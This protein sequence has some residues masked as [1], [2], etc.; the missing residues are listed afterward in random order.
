MR[1]VVLMALAATALFFN[2]NAQDSTPATT[3]EDKGK[4]TFSG[5][6]D[7]YYL[8]NFNKPLS[9]LNT[10]ASGLDEGGVT[11]IGGNA[12]AFDAV[13][14]QF[15]LG[16]VQT[17][18]VYS[19]KKSEAVIDLTFGPNADLGNYGNYVGPLGGGST[20]LAIKQAYFTYKATD[21]L[22]FTAGQFGTHIGYEVIDAPI[23]YNYSLS[24]LFNNGPF[25]HIGL[26]GTYA[27]S[28]KVALMAGIVNN[29]DNL[30]DNNRAK[31]IISQLYVQPV[32]GWN[33]YLN[34]IGSN[35]APSQTT[36]D[37]AYYSLFD[38][39]TSYQVTEKFF[40][41]L[42]AAMGS[43]KAGSGQDANT[44][45]GVALYSNVAISDVFGLGARY[46]YFDNTSGVRAVRNGLGAGTTVN[47]VTVTGNFTLADGHL[48]IKPEYRLDSYPKLSGG[49]N[50]QHQK[51]E[52][53][54]GVFSKNTQSTLTLAFIYKF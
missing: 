13:A 49:G 10:G 23:N 8:G 24:N 34:W 22:S 15:S 33:V 26:K 17:K 44:W 2:A 32:S 4:F 54:D 14:G 48:L 20:A 16:L 35:E 7:S 40:L 47:S 38:L 27:F 46:E 45:G 42:N 28:D 50:E 43:E 30:Y 39:T 19:N 25:Y 29:I 18:A 31:A 9:R 36:V 1:K 3:E 53:S 52:D 51:F 11:V 37:G 5:Y 6:L 21:K 41:G 12:R